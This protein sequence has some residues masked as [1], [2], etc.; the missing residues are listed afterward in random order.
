[1]SV[2][3]Y[4]QSIARLT[5]PVTMRLTLFLLG[6]L[7]AAFAARPARAQLSLAD[8]LRAADTRAVA[9]RMAAG[10]R[11]A[12]DAQA[13]A[14]LHGILPSARVE[15]S[16]VRTDD[17]I[18]AF[19]TELRQRRIAQADFDPS[20]LNFPA[21]VTN[22]GGGLVLELPLLNADAW[23][24]RTATMRGAS[25]ARASES[26]THLSTRADV[27]RAFYGAVLAAERVTTLDA[28]VRAARAHVRDAESLARNGVVTPSDAMLADVK[29]GE[30]EAD[31]IGARADAALARRGLAVLIGG[32]GNSSVE[33]A[34]TIPAATTLRTFAA[35]DTIVAPE[36][37]ADV[38]AARLGAEASSADVQRA[39]ALL[40]PR[41][42]A[43]ARTDWN[44]PGRLF[45]GE[46]NWTAGVMASWSP[47]SGAS[48]LAEQRGAQARAAGA[49]AMADGAAANARLESERSLSDLRVALDRL[50]IAE[51]SAAQGMDAHRIVGRRYDGGLATVV[52]LLDAAAAE[53][54]TATALAKARYDVVVA[55][56]SRRLALGLD[57][58]A[59]A[60]L[61][62]P[63]S[64]RPTSEDVPR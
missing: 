7:V 32:D 25:A 39:R 44:D 47:F 10:D 29:A 21:P 35:T 12:R 54:H 38:D 58:G 42:N 11:S 30:L 20:R 28:A 24:A 16:I 60:N 26:W 34:G 31:L 48:E 59:V 37:R 55:L 2:Y 52:E 9:N 46:R 45:A 23:I 56:A 51:H 50:V 27:V 63:A 13:I 36:A 19:G 62:S 53:V 14:P 4:S 33:P 64:N 17:P 49:R 18:G 61:E 1:M 57:P 8:A 3:S 43:F 40:L 15:A 41:L 6:S 5:S 22:Y